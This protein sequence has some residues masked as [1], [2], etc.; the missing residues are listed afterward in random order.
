MEQQ[1][2]DA[3]FE[4]FSRQFSDLALTLAYGSQLPFGRTPMRAL[5][6]SWNALD[7]EGRAMVA[8]R[9]AQMVSS[10]TPVLADAPEG[11]TE[12]EMSR[13]Q[14]FRSQ[15]GLS[16]RSAAERA[17]DI[18]GAFDYGERVRQFGRYANEGYVSLPGLASR[19]PD[20]SYVLAAAGDDRFREQTLRFGEG[21]HL[22]VNDIS[23]MTIR[24]ALDRVVMPAVEREA[25]INEMPDGPERDE[26]LYQNGYKP[27]W[28]LWAKQNMPML[29]ELRSHLYETVDGRTGDTVRVR[30]LVDPYATTRMTPARVLEDIFNNRSADFTE[31]GLKRYFS[32]RPA[33]AADPRFEETDIKEYNVYSLGMGRLSEPDFW[34]LVPED[35]DV[36]VFLRG[37][38]ANK[39]NPQFARDR[40]N[41]T[42]QQRGIEAVAWPVLAARGDEKD[43]MKKLM[44][45]SKPHEVAQGGLLYVDYGAL[46]EDEGFQKAVDEQILKYV[47]EGK[48]VCVVG[49]QSSC[50][51][52]TG[53]S[54]ALLL[55]QY[56]ENNTDFRVAHIDG[57]PDGHRVRVLSQEQACMQ[58]LP[59]RSV[60]DG[61]TTKDLKFLNPVGSGQ[62]AARFTL[63]LGVEIRRR[64]AP[65]QDPAL[66]MIEGRWNYGRPVEFREMEGTEAR[67]AG[68]GYFYDSVNENIDHA[69]FTVIFAASGKGADHNVQETMSLT[70][71][72]DVRKVFIPETAEEC[73]DPEIIEK[74][75]RSIGS[76]LTRSLAY[77]YSRLG[78]DIVD[79]DNVKLFVTGSSLPRIAN[80]VVETA[81]MEDEYGETI[82]GFLMDTPL[83]PSQDDAT[84]FI[85]EVLRRV[86]QD[87]TDNL[88]ID[89]EKRLFTVGE[90]CNH[91]D[92]G[93]CEAA[94]TAAQDLGIRPVVISTNGAFTEARGDS[95][96]GQIVQDPAYFH[97]RAHRGLRH[98]VS[99]AMV[100][101]QIDDLEARRQ[102][103]TDGMQI[104]LT[105][106]QMLLLYEL[107]VENGTMLEAMD[108]A[109]SNEMTLNTADEIVDFLDQCRSNGL[110][111]PVDIDAAAVEAAFDRVVDNEERWREA[112]IS[113]ITAAS[114]LYPESM[115]NF[116]E[117]TEMRTRPLVETTVDGQ[118]RISSEE[119]EYTVRR[120]AVLWCRG[121]LSL[122]QEPSVGILGGNVTDSNADQSVVREFCASVTSDDLPVT[123]SLDD[124]VSRRG[125]FDTLA[126]VGGRV[127]AVT[128]EPFSTSDED[129]QQRL[130]AA[131][132]RVN[133]LNEAVAAANV[134]PE[135]TLRAALERV[136]ADGEMSLM[137]AE[138]VTEVASDAR[139]LFFAMSQYGAY[140]REAAE[141][142]PTDNV[143]RAVERL[144]DDAQAERHLL[145]SSGL[146]E[147]ADAQNEVV[148]KGGLVVTDQQPDS[149]E[150][151]RRSVSQRLVAGM[152]SVAVVF[153]QIHN[154]QP[155]GLMAM[156]FYTVAGLTYITTR[157]IE[158]IASNL[159]AAAEERRREAADL[160]RQAEESDRPGVRER[161]LAVAR[162]RED[163]ARQADVLAN[164]VPAVAMQVSSDGRNEE[165]MPTLREAGRLAAEQARSEHEAAQQRLEERVAS[166]GEEGQKRSVYSRVRERLSSVFG[167]DFD[168]LFNE[169]KPEGVAAPAEEAA[170]PQRQMTI[171]VL[172]YRGNRIFF[173][174]D[175]QP[176]IAEA[177][178]ERF[179]KDAQ[180]MDPSLKR[181]VQEGLDLGRVEGHD[182]F[183][184]PEGTML[185]RPSCYS[186]KVYFHEGVVYSINN[187]PTGIMG[188]P[189]KA[190]RVKSAAAW[191][192]FMDNMQAFQREWMRQ[193]GLPLQSG[194]AQLRCENADYMVFAPNRIEVRRGD[195]LRCFVEYKDGVI[196]AGN[197]KIKDLSEYHET[198][199]YDI[200][201]NLPRPGTPLL[202]SALD[203][204]AKD[205]REALG[206]AAT[207]AQKP[208]YV[209]GASHQETWENLRSNMDAFQKLVAL[210]LENKNKELVA[211][212]KE[213]LKARAEI[214]VSDNRIEV[215]GNTEQG[216]TPLC[217]VEFRD[218]AIYA[219]NTEG[220]FAL[221]RFPE[222]G[223]PLTEIDGIAARL[224]EMVTNDPE[225]LA[226][227]AYYAGRP[228]SE[229]RAL[230]E[231]MADRAKKEEYEEKIA[232]GF[233]KPRADNMSIAVEDVAKALY[234]GRIPDMSEFQRRDPVYLYAAASRA[235]TQARAAVRSLDRQIVRQQTR[236][237]ALEAA[238]AAKGIDIAESDAARQEMED[239][240][241][242]LL[243]HRRKNIEEVA[244]ME[245]VKSSLREGVIPFGNQNQVMLDGVPFTVRNV[246]PTKEEIELAER[247]LGRKAETPVEAPAEKK[248]EDQA[249]V[250]EE[251]REETREQAPAEEATVEAPAQ[252]E[253]PQEAP[254]EGP[255][256]SLPPEERMKEI[257]ERLAS[258][259]EENPDV[260]E[261][262]SYR[263]L[264]LQRDALQK[265]IYRNNIVP[266]SEKNGLV[267]VN[268]PEGQRYCDK[269]MNAVSEAYPCLK[270]MGTTIGVAYENA[271]GTGAMKIIRRDGSELS[272]MWFSK[273]SVSREPMVAVLTARDGEG[274]Y[275]LN[276]ETGVITAGPFIAV[277]DYREGRA[278]VQ[279][280]DG[281]YNFVNEK[282]DLVQKSMWF[283]DAQ[284]FH[285]GTATVRVETPSETH[286]YTFDRDF[287][288]KG[289]EKQPKERA[290]APKK[291][292]QKKPEQKKPEQ[293]S[294]SQGITKK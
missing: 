273:F 138:Q 249:P 274:K 109:I 207:V 6:A 277:Q 61:G 31:E 70:H 209:Q 102:S 69:N 142:Y 179:G 266:D 45:Q 25:S 17:M 173:V 106:R 52:G 192:L 14:L 161:T 185:L 136:S 174:P 79:L 160:R 22:G 33:I 117:Y 181:K 71:G 262:D 95:I 217:F 125:V 72:R 154:A 241:E 222:K 110:D 177:V 246:R 235:A 10:L 250:Q 119:Y 54:R 135:A 21:T 234:E 216:M 63:P 144:R 41:E 4:R 101:E 283:D 260:V 242:E 47:R 163:S 247:E 182:R 281:R 210:R 252:K 40:L 203:E 80:R 34:R 147:T 121:D 75:A 67:I 145:K 232:N 113:Y 87:R 268:T 131:G 215:L 214:V 199:T 9:L 267:I 126:N 24:E 218:G 240:L 159:R 58:A 73:Y 77:Q 127:V 231:T 56:I 20:E 269:D 272:P 94:I 244:N 104:G 224:R 50:Y 263:D 86:T 156:T 280:E 164:R 43:N 198:P 248:A 245:D 184:A 172:S 66:R 5:A 39:Y 158:K 114:P 282:G 221:P 276:R 44:G 176:H 230:E 7:G 228:R 93:A 197:V 2:L 134:V 261:E 284:H 200:I 140:I 236:L 194:F 3:L 30:R 120:P 233:L 188:L 251:S 170:R 85:T 122:L 178:R 28:S 189:P 97:N 265:D 271:D 27:L 258:M 68:S 84:Y 130:Q 165:T 157:P 275:I 133:V 151:P 167:I 255:A 205:I 88:E 149:K 237:D 60:I 212:G 227:S 229:Q 243:V 289:F 57:G 168:T 46:S 141:K 59:P 64:M 65:G 81:A 137:D 290:A 171:D 256:A 270:R 152:A 19:H 190:E 223:V 129:L 38:A 62:K 51:R 238:T 162:R 206:G 187:V 12:E 15:R 118:A 91:Y 89:G 36:M 191:K 148:R 82:E 226:R 103:A 42:A 287:H 78:A 1:Q 49:A 74:A 8:G 196:R 186:Y 123:A 96:Y 100:I 211:N 193:A 105:D 202:P 253:S 239:K 53:A 285:N 107:G 55:G 169:K 35:T 213:P 153:D 254:A 112:G 128:G 132:E 90:I 294:S 18:V 16:L 150:A 98:E 29:R 208:L 139:S 279:R 124:D 201:S 23:G 115:R 116:Q 111:I 108:L 146:S 155:M 143:A 32:D 92:T 83:G 219:D 292:E 259:V 264:L 26:F 11:A 48:K 288:Q 183:S 180:I 204:V 220:H 37:T 286:Y 225:L 257:D 99:D 166:I 13:A 278:R 291:P 76:A 195:E 175:S 293:A